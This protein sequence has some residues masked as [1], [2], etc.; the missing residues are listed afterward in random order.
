[1]IFGLRQ[2]VEHATLDVLCLNA[3]RGG[4]KNDARDETDG[5]ETIMLT[6][7]YGRL[8]RGAVASLSADLHRH[9]LNRTHSLIYI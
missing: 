3:G 9:V 7:V 4:A 6:N 5:M 8:S 2:V 1:V